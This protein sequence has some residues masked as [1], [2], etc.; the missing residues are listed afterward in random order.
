MLI[1]NEETNSDYNYSSAVVPI[2]DTVGVE[3]NGKLGVLKPFH[4]R[5][6]KR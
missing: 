4:S 5:M 3:F 1:T 6:D 2:M